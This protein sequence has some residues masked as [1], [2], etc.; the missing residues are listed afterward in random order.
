[1]SVETAKLI[2]QTT[3]PCPK[4]GLRIHKASGCDQMWCI[5][6]KTT[7]SWNTG[8]IVTGGII[9][10]PHYFQYLRDHSE[11]GI[12]LGNLVMILML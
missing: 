2:R 9:H 11:N 6:C 8:E 3:K 10:N 7:F 1:M 5:D 12:I 4:C